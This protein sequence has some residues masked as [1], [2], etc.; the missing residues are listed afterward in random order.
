MIVILNNESE[1]KAWIR[2][3]RILSKYLP[4]I[5]SRS[6]AGHISEEGLNDLHLA[7]KK[8]ASKAGSISCHRVTSRNHLELQW[9]AG[10]KKQFD[11][12]GRFCFRT[13]ASRPEFETPLSSGRKVMHL[14]VQLAALLHDIG[15][16][17]QAFQA[18][19]QGKYLAE[20]YRHDLMGFL[21]LRER[22]AQYSTDQDW[23][24]DFINQSTTALNW[25]ADS[26]IP[27]N[28]E[29]SLSGTRVASMLEKT[30][31]LFSLLW[32]VL[33]H[34]R[35]PTG[36]IDLQFESHINETKEG[37]TISIAPKNMCLKLA[38]GEMPWQN[39]GWLQAVASTS[40][41]LLDL[42]NEPQS[43]YQEINGFINHWILITAHWARPCLIYADH[44]AS[45][46]KSVSGEVS[47][48]QKIAPLANTVSRENASE[49]TR[50]AGDTLQT[51]LTKAR[52]YSR[53]AL[54]VSA[55]PRSLFRRASISSTSAF[56]SSSTDVRY[57]WQDSLASVIE[58]STNGL[59]PAFVGI[60]AGTGCGKTLAGV[61]AMYAL[62]GGSMRYT[63]ALGL[64]SLTLQSA[65]AMLS[66]AGFNSK[67]VAV[68][69]G[70][71][72]ATQWIE[73]RSTQLRQHPSDT[74]GSENANPGDD[75]FEMQL[76]DGSAIH[77]SVENLP[78]WV[79]AFSLGNDGV[80][81]ETSAALFEGVKHR[82]M[83]DMPIL[84]CT[85]DHLVAAV[86]MRT[87]GSA[88]MALRMMTSDLVLDEIDAYSA[89]DLQSIGK[90]AMLTGMAGKSVVVMSATANDIV[91]SGIY[92]A[93]AEGLKAK[94]LLDGATTDLGVVVLADQMGKPK[95]L[96]KHNVEAVRSAHQE[97]VAQMFHAQTVIKQR[98]DVLDLTHFLSTGDVS[99]TA[100]EESQLRNLVFEKIYR[101]SL[102]LARKNFSYDPKTGIELS[103]GFVR[104][105][106]AKS[107][108]HFAK[109]LV[110]NDQQS[111]EPEIRTL[112]YHSKHPRIVLGQMDGALNKILL[113]HN[114]EDIWK[115][116]AIRQAINAAQANHRRSVLVIISTTTLQETGR[117]HDYDWAILEPRSVRGEIQATGRVRRHRPEPWHAVNVM[118]LS[119]PLRSI[120]N[121]T[122]PH[123]GLPGIEESEK[124]NG[125]KNPFGI[126]LSQNR[127]SQLIE[128]K[129]FEELGIEA[130][131]PLGGTV[132]A[133][134]RNG[135]PPPRILSSSVKSALEVLPINWWQE[136]GINSSASLN[137]RN[138]KIQ[139]NIGNLEALS[140]HLHLQSTKVV[141]TLTN[142]NFSSLAQYLNPMQGMQL[143]L[144]KHHAQTARFRQG[145]K[146]VELLTTQNS[147]HGWV[148]SWSDDSGNVQQYPH[149]TAYA[150]QKN[151]HKFLLNGVIAFEAL[152]SLPKNAAIKFG[153]LQWQLC[154]VQIDQFYDTQPK[155]T[156]EVN[157]GFLVGS[158]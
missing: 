101:C 42:I 137:F 84:A 53:R 80:D 39:Q 110:E 28:I 146:T 134:M 43:V 95:C 145:Q 34:H 138:P 40:K 106:H 15:K 23:L 19:L 30:P 133:R 33:T 118:I 156:Y 70:Q 21:M 16:A 86:E 51:H 49:K 127:T 8:V 98:L 10:N 126:G 117:D 113:R 81:N 52:R 66:Q 152:P 91:I 136:G 54:L 151:N 132:P 76:L 120:V 111:D 125:G 79:R 85:A 4:Q 61:R 153:S 72:Q 77:A 155:V 3:R 7:L 103:L 104:F 69:I 96:L 17:T 75:F 68:A 48:A 131:A 154:V 121:S 92:N 64:R 27:A 1:G 26:I 124:N 149:A 116:D 102:D 88:R 148:V 100:L 142:Q 147:Q 57:K 44:L 24:G 2:T 157:L 119:H 25:D 31:L 82:A 105:N 74:E 144:T 109:F 97:L 45:I 18:K 36:S 130:P 112:S 59:R 63:L 71:P 93:W 38:E 41:Q 67:D 158:V 107:A 20:Y 94:R 12:V 99:I 58:Q 128:Q 29:P 90:L 6:W 56:L 47:D 32:L 73:N 139:S 129:A 55:N 108:W 78:A 140:Q 22:T 135:R 141:S 115:H 122:T 11:E 114:P 89:Q 50:L 87:G 37:S 62:S 5:G 83:I 9:I 14:T 35:L 65:N 123:W 60:I 13:D 46:A 143:A 150:I